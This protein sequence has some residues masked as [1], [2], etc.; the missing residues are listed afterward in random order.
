MKCLQNVSTNAIQHI[1]LDSEFSILLH[2]L[3]DYSNDEPN[4]SISIDMKEIYKEFSKQYDFNS[5]ESDET[6]L[7]FLS[8]RQ[9]LHALIM[10]SS[11]IKTY[12]TTIRQTILDTLKTNRNLNPVLFED[13]KNKY[14]FFDGWSIDFLVYDDYIIDNNSNNG[15]NSKNSKNNKSVSI[16]AY[17]DKIIEQLM[18]FLHNQE[19][20]T[21]V[22]RL[23]TFVRLALK[24]HVST[25]ISK[26]LPNYDDETQ[27]MEGGK[28]LG[29]GTYGSVWKFDSENYVSELSKFGKKNSNNELTISSFELVNAKTNTVKS[30][31]VESIP[32][33][34]S[35]YVEKTVFKRFLTEKHR[36]EEVVAIKRVLEAFNDEDVLKQYSML[37][38]E[39]NYPVSLAKFKLE[40]ANS[41][42]PKQKLKPWH[43][44]L[45]Q[46]KNYRL[47]VS[48]IPY[49]ACKGDITEFMKKI[50]FEQVLELLYSVSTFMTNIGEKQLVHLDIKPSNILY[51]K[52]YNFYVGDYGTIDKKLVAA[53]LMYC[54]PLIHSLYTKS[55]TEIENN[56]YEVKKYFK[57][58]YGIPKSQKDVK[59]RV[60][61][62][63]DTIQG[64]TLVNAYCKSNYTYSDLQR[65]DMYSLAITILEILYCN[66]VIPNENYINFL[67]MQAISLIIP[68]MNYAKAIELKMKQFCDLYEPS[69]YFDWNHLQEIM[70]R[71]IQEM[72][73]I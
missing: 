45:A 20:K 40:Y 73:E 7:M 21:I 6:P 64:D 48:L 30:I 51:D 41:S 50:S 1:N 43:G 56:I 12:E 67:F 2:S 55:R 54:S 60:L 17:V 53:T 8:F 39:N 34:V 19:N 18:L 37:S 69:Y 63:L 27:P 72:R 4:S 22:I 52:E 11:Y 14:F 42:N 26:Y 9:A 46:K 62:F 3:V 32:S 66:T 31:P 24:T 29:K 25:F 49:R 33:S 57:R 5:S 23:C 35:N 47:N 38:Y 65:S 13:G 36:N 28:M 58:K 59:G 61:A 44:G 70:Y 16:G 68:N 15:N 10:N 71:E